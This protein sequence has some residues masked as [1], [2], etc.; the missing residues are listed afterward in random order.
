M[1][2]KEMWAAISFYEKIYQS[3]T[4]YPLMLHAKS[5]EVRGITQKSKL[6]YFYI[7]NILI[8]F[9]SL[10]YLVIIFAAWLDWDVAEDIPT[11]AVI[12]LAYSLYSATCFSTTWTKP[13]SISYSRVGLKLNRHW[14]K[15]NEKHICI[16]N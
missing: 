10:C 14:E 6:K 8:L 2:S 7:S 4:N 12:C 15:V 11:W 13:K 16:P 1:S 3:H 5:K 9:V